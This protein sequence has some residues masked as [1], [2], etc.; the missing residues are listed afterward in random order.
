MQPWRRITAQDY[1]GCPWPA[2]RRRRWRSVRS[3]AKRE[4]RE[5]HR[6]AAAAPVEVVAC[7]THRSVTVSSTSTMPQ[8]L[9]QALRVLRVVH[10]VHRLMD[11]MG[12]CQEIVAHCTP[13][14]CLAPECS[15][16]LVVRRATS[17][18]RG[19]MR[20]SGIEP[21]KQFAT[22]VLVSWNSA[23]LESQPS[24]RARWRTSMPGVLCQLC[25]AS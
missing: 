10:R 21:P 1:C 18:S 6:N 5:Q 7:S 23:L 17:C 4:Q 13:Q 16:P 24:A 25:Q 22:K 12:Q 15:Q 2:S 3:V 8:G 14:T 19:G 9:P 20:R 11:A